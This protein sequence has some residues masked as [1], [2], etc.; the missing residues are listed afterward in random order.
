LQDIC[1]QSTVRASD[2]LYRVL[3]TL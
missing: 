1:S 2:T 3:R